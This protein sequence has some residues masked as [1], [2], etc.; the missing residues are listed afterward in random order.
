MGVTIDQYRAAIGL[1]HARI[2]IKQGSNRVSL[3]DI[4]EN[5]LPGALLNELLFQCKYTSVVLWLLFVHIQTGNAITSLYIYM[6]L[7]IWGNNVESN[8][9]PSSQ[10]D[11]ATILS[12][13]HINIRSLR[14]KISCL[15]DIA[16]EYDIICVSETHLDEN[17]NTSDIKIDEYYPN[18]IRK[19]RNAHGGVLLYTSPKGSLSNGKSI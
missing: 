16:S 2:F 8:P 18:P 6:L 5:L 3:Y 1:F 13:F 15:S 19:D 7:I 17:V 9:G 12:V 4:L 11:D 14:N 10:T